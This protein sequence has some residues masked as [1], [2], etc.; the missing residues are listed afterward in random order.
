MTLLELKKEVDDV[1]NRGPHQWALDVVVVLAEDSIGAVAHSH[2]RSVGTGID[3]DSGK[4]M[5]FPTDELIRE[6]NERQ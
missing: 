6:T 2:V 3:W 1:I 4:F 5:I